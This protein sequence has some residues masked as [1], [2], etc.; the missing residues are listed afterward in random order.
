MSGGNPATPAA[1]VVGA[2]PIEYKIEGDNLQIV[3]IKLKPGQDVYAEAGKMVYKTSSVEWETRMTGKG[4]GGKALWRAEAQARR[5]IAF[6]DPLSYF[7]RR[8]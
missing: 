1:P 6:H 7:G 5:G 8:G 3:R 2:T 4:L